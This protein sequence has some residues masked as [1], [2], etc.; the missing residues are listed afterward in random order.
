MNEA[1][2]AGAQWIVQKYMEA[3][4]LIANRKFDMRQWVLVTDWNPLTVWFY[5]EAYLRFSVDEY[6]DDEAAMSN[7]FV[8]MVNNSISKGSE[9]FTEKVVAENGDEFANGFMWSQDQFKAFC[10]WKTGGADDAAFDN[11]RT[12]L[13]DIAVHSLMCAQDQIEHRKNSWELCVDEGAL[14]LLLLRPTTCC[15][16][17]PAATLLTSPLLLGTGTTSWSARTSSRRL[18]RSTRRRRATTRRA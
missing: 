4:L 10:K 7:S 15:H 3:S 6:T 12:R 11:V 18:S 16:S 5:D 14:P 13:K 17:C 1:T 9:K 8:H 2:N